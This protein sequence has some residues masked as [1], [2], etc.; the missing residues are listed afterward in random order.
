MM[1]DSSKCK[2]ES[3]IISLISR[4]NNKCGACP[5]CVRLLLSSIDRT[6]KYND[7]DSTMMDNE[8]NMKQ[9][10]ICLGIYSK[11][12]IWE[13]SSTYAFN[14]EHELYKV[15]QPYYNQY[16]FWNGKDDN[17]EK[18]SLPH[19]LIFYSDAP[20][21]SLPCDI[22]VRAY[23]ALLHI[24]SDHLNNI[25]DIDI[26]DGA[27][28]YI[29]QLKQ[30][31]KE[32]IRSTLFLKIHNKLETKY[33][34]MNTHLDSHQSR[35]PLNLSNEEGTMNLHIILHSNINH[36]TTNN[37][38]SSFKS[39]P[40]FPPLS[41]FPISLQIPYKKQRKRFRGDDPT[42]KQGGSPITNLE[43]KIQ[44]GNT[45][46]SSFLPISMSLIQKAILALE[47]EKSDKQSSL[48]NWLLQETKMNNHHHSSK[49][50]FSIHI[51]A[52][53]RPFYIKGRYTKNRR[54]ISQ[55]P[56]FVSSITSSSSINQNNSDTNQF[57]SHFNCIKKPM[58][59]KGVTSVQEQICS[60]IT[61]TCSGI[62]TQNNINEKEEDTNGKIVYG[63]CKFHASGR[64]DID[65]R[66]LGNGRPFA[67]EIIDAYQI[68]TISDLNKA[69]QYIHHHNNNDT[70]SKNMSGVEISKLSFTN[71]KQFSN[72]QLE[73]EDKVK[74]YACICWSQSKIPTQMHLDHK[75]NSQNINRKHP[76]MIV[77]ATPIRVLHRRSAANRIRY[78]VSL[79]SKRIND[80]WF[81]L[82]V[83]TSAGTYVKE[84]VRGDL[85]RTKPS[86]ASMLND[87]GSLQKV[88]I[89]QLD[90]MGI[91]DN[92]FTVSKKE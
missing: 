73:T 2:K 49:C 75:L 63:M 12:S 25:H 76:L 33:K 84:F 60:V 38:N 1:T 57:S 47:K 44:K 28:V 88:D 45:T 69:E 92:G 42:I 18:K 23:T 67:L 51:A 52:W 40:S 4:L 34:E 17:D 7:I 80:H 82:W 32:Y 72:L 79:T 29:D 89:L 81:Q 36:L 56:F 83:S 31:M 85:G 3:N 21:I 39:F 50:A 54:N 66:M 86:I 16:P 70:R 11:N 19:S 59:R 37:E 10:Q 8:N 9:C 68:P 46:N 90:V 14:M 78:I 91:D 20:S 64:E 5:T 55:S 48:N 65:V 27:N 30:K 71:A 58:I 43:T 53:R 41:I 77:Q 6:N 26:I 74:H 35:I 61:K 62:S 87:D 22:Y 13:F 24:R 15:L